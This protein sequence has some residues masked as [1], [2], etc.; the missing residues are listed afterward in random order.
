[1]LHTSAARNLLTVVGS[2]STDASEEIHYLLTT[3]EDIVYTA[4]R[5]SGRSWILMGRAQYACTCGKM[6]SQY[7]NLYRHQKQE[8][9]KEPAFR[10]VHC[11]YKCFR[12]NV[13][14]MHYKSRHHIFCKETLKLL[15]S[16]KNP[17]ET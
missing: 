4:K 14:F 5:H 15:V 7:R 13:M 3:G 2:V 11:D 9:G 10:C 17:N 1:M 6:Y 8:C 12:R 16:G